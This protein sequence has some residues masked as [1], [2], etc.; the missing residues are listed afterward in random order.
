MAEQGVGPLTHSETEK[1]TESQEEQASLKFT[2]KLEAGPQ[3]GGQEPLRLNLV[4]LQLMGSLGPGENGGWGCANMNLGAGSERVVLLLRTGGQQAGEKLGWQQEWGG[5]E[6][7]SDEGPVPNSVQA[8]VRSGLS[9]PVPHE[10][11]LRGS[12]CIF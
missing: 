6:Q 10:E 11:V 1:T 12:V 7:T 9:R 8:R 2:E 3:A 4:R 5:G